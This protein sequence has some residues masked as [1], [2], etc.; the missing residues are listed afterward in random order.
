[1]TKTS[2]NGLLFQ[3]YF[4]YHGDN[5]ILPKQIRN[6]F[7]NHDLNAAS[8]LEIGCGSGR[9][10]PNFYELLPQ[11]GM[12][13][14]L[15]ISPEQ[16]VLARKHI[17]IL[18]GFPESTINL[19]PKEVVGLVRAL[20][21][22]DLH[23]LD[24][25]DR[26]DLNCLELRF[27]DNPPY[28][29]P[30]PSAIHLNPGDTQKVEAIRRGFYKANRRFNFSR[31]ELLVGDAKALPFPDGSFDTVVMNDV[32]LYFPPEEAKTVLDQAQR[33]AKKDL[34]FTTYPTREETLGRGFYYCLSDRYIAIL[35]GFL[36]FYYP[37]PAQRSVAEFAGVPDFDGAINLDEPKSGSSRK[38]YADQYQRAIDNLKLRLHHEIP[39]GAIR[40]FSNAIRSD[41]EEWLW[42]NFLDRGD[43]FYLYNPNDIT[44]MIGACDVSSGHTGAMMDAARFVFHKKK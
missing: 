36:P 28:M 6:P 9:L 25:L 34:L 16:I 43:T 44:K 11:N 26:G 7:T 32:L 29:N 41:T 33:V 21:Y 1:M 18:E 37:K 17:K 13:V 2:E 20:E 30:E 24:W 38:R 31:L 8:I 4:R 14:G 19:Q 23:Y 3:D 5:F 27:L 35:L 42:R 15:D 39:I 40:R 12:L 22:F 10:L